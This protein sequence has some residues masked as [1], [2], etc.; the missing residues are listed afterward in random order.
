MFLF[1]IL[2]ADLIFKDVSA[3][4]IVP[5]PRLLI[6]LDAVDSGATV[7][8]SMSLFGLIFRTVNNYGS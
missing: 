3:F 6:L 1:L 4:L 2:V 7:F 5:F 8:S